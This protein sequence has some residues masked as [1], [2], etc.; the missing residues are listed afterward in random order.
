MAQAAGHVAD[1]YGMAAETGARLGAAAIEATT[2]KRLD[3]PKFNS[4]SN[5]GKSLDAGTLETGKFYAETSV[6]SAS[7]GV[8]G[9]G[10]SSYQYATGQISQQEWSENL[11]ATGI[12]QAIPAAVKY[13]PRLLK[14]SPA[15]TTEV[16]KI[17]GTGEAPESGVVYRRTN[18]KTGEQ[19]IGQAKS[20]QHFLRRQSAH[21][22]KLR[23]KHEY[24]IVERAKPGQALDVAEEGWIRQGGGPAN[25]SN[26]GGGLA[27]KRHQMN[28][29]R[30]RNAGGTI[31]KDY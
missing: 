15:A 29:T 4:L 3:T 8:Y 24:E 28:E 9:Q 1:Q 5:V 6:N 7:F 25:E 22:S 14:G 2:G 17:K 10:K 16:A 26:P 21:D 12:G 18:P 20:D 11:I 23:V 13:G 30:Y 19:Y 31:D 27:N